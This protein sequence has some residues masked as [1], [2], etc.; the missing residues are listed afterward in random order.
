M[1]SLP[2][3]ASGKAPA[4]PQPHAQ[5]SWWPHRRPGLP[6]ACKSSRPSQQAQQR[7]WEDEGEAGT[8][9]ERLA[10]QGRQAKAGGSKK[11]ERRWMFGSFGFL[12]LGEAGGCLPACFIRSEKVHGLGGIIL[13]Q[14]TLCHISV[15]TVA[16]TAMVFQR[17]LSQFCNFLAA[18]LK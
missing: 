12:G 10:S 9:K 1:V 17:L 18:A 15:V 8:G 14:P 11:G 6:H 13:W 7:E 5:H 4:P 16:H 2:P 3:P